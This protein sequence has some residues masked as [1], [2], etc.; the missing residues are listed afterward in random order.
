MVETDPSMLERPSIKVSSTLRR[1]FS[2]TGLPAFS[3]ELSTCVET[4]GELRVTVDMFVC[5]DTKNK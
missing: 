4:G 3:D 5:L 1:R 2:G